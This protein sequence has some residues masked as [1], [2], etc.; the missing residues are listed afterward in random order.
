MK[1]IIERLLGNQGMT[2]EQAYELM[3]HQMHGVFND[4]QIA[5]FLI[6]LRAKGV[7][8]EELVGFISAMQENIEPVP[9]S[10][11][12]I[13][14]C[15]T[16]G[17]IKEVFN[18]STAAGL[19]AAGAGVPVAKHGTRHR[20]LSSGAADVLT[21]LGVDVY[22]PPEKVARN[23]DEIGFGFMYAPTLHPVIEK[24]AYITRSL[25]V[26]TVFDIV[27]PLCNPARVK[28][29]VFGVYSTTLTDL[30]ARVLK[31]RG[32]REAFIVNGYDGM[33][34]LTTTSSTK[35]SHLKINGEIESS[36]LSPSDFKLQTTPLE[37]LIGG[38]PKA[39]AQIILKILDGNSSPGRDV[40][41][42]N[43]AAAIM[44]G[45]KA[46]SIQE[47]MELAQESIDSGAARKILRRLA[48][49]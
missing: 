46:E 30:V 43:A 14:I 19:V 9:I 15:G 23:V 48:A 31:K 33:D 8:S 41:I 44:V 10:S 7:S 5:G 25:D 1:S 21:S 37:N 13:D 20:D 4:A 22:L 49:E 34:E 11:D 3:K 6:A 28:R 40:V 29:Q 35:V 32:T 47:G 45:G 18:I 39:N 38:S 17:D 27:S 2:R 24:M 16:G 12:A 36:I 42:L 26:R